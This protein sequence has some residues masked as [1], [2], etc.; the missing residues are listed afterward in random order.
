[1]SAESVSA[2]NLYNHP[3]FKELE[4]F[5]KLLIAALE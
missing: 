2:S 4:Q 3:G 1:M 5:G